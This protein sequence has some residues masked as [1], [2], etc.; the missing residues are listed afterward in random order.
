MPAQYG[1]PLL[2]QHCKYVT[3]KAV[4]NEINPL[5]FKSLNKNITLISTETVSH[6]LLKSLQNMVNKGNYHKENRTSV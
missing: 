2:A 1:V 5:F 4:K 6:C 3:S